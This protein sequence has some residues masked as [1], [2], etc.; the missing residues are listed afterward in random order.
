MPTERTC[1]PCAEVCADNGCVGAEPHQCV[2]CDYAYSG[3]DC[4]SMCPHSTYLSRIGAPTCAPCSIMCD[5]TVSG[6]VCTGPSPTDCIRCANVSRSGV[7]VVACNAT[8]EYVDVTGR[9]M[10]CHPQCSGGC[11]G[12]SASECTRCTRWTMP[13][14]TCVNTC[15]SAAYFADT[16]AMQCQH[17]DATCAVDSG[18]PLGVGPQHC[19]RCQ[20]FEYGD[21]CVAD[22]PVGSF[23]R[24]RISSGNG[25]STAPPGMADFECTP[26]H[27]LCDVSGGCSGP[28]ASDC[29]NCTMFQLVR[30][31]P[32]STSFRYSCV[33]TCPSFTY[34]RGRQCLECDANCLTGC[35]GGGATNCTPSPSISLSAASLGCRTA[36]YFVGDGGTQCSEECPVTHFPD[37]N[38]ICQA[39]HVSCGANGCTGAS[40]ADCNACAAPME[41]LDGDVGTCLPCHVECVGGCR[42][43]RATDCVACAHA[44]RDEECV[45]NCTM[46]NTSRYAYVDAG[47][48]V[49]CLR[50]SALCDV[51]LGCT[52]GTASDCTACAAFETIPARTCVSGCPDGTYATGLQCLACHSSCARSCVGPLASQCVECQGVRLRNGTCAHVCP[53]PE[54]VGGDGRCNCPSDRAYVNGSECVPCHPQCTSGCTG[55]TAAAC[56]GGVV[57]C[58]SGL[59]DTAGV[60]ID[61]CPPPADTTDG[62]CACPAARAFPVADGSCVACDLE[63][64]RGCSGQAPWE[65][66][67]FPASCAHAYVDYP[68]FGAQYRRCVGTCPANMYLRDDAAA[69]CVCADGFHVTRTTP[70]SLHGI[71]VA[72]D[73]VCATCDGPGVSGCTACKGLQDGVS[74]ACVENCPAL[75]VANHTTD[76]CLPCDGQCA[77]GCIA[78]SDPRACVTNTSSRRRC[79]HF[80]DEDIGC[81]AHCPQTR[82]FVYE[83]G[84]GER[85]CASECPVNKPF[86]NDTRGVTQSTLTLEQEP[87][88][89]AAESAT[90]SN[91][92]GPLYEQLCVASCAALRNT[93]LNTVNS[94]HSTMCSP[95]N[96]V[97]ADSALI[98][99]APE[100]ET[101]WTGMV[102]IAVI[103]V[104]LVVVVIAAVVWGR[105]NA[106][107]GQQ[108]MVTP[109]PPG[110]AL[111]PMAPLPD[112]GGVHFSPSYVSAYWQHRGP[113]PPLPADLS[114]LDGSTANGRVMTNPH[115]QARTTL[116]HVQYADGTGSS[117]AVQDTRV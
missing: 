49:A 61:T 75:T 78:P 32:A 113:S 45:P 74:G 54:V 101:N 60:C 116:S 26:C 30:W 82:F 63:C 104:V 109:P 35:R 87:A 46:F 89:E 70:T 88:S 19:A 56:N 102:V 23:V 14:G 114:A 94:N 51:R 47:G 31:H 18:C 83:D 68:A 5:G 96:L 85:N 38:G 66:A 84:S 29:N 1:M 98:R 39:C 103:V 16:T 28:L 77:A 25:S 93:T 44:R 55:P 97:S 99:P 4:V 3:V 105:R 110:I 50:C 64:N 73:G 80:R 100:E 53:A 91:I 106:R 79:R 13:D 58:R 2:T 10:A 76:M 95:D 20:Q 65:C 12:P 7:C 6:T 22:C 59:I 34:R 111:A 112:T 107:T 108:T 48:S 72:C 117:A 62:I 36:A 17:C 37:D 92:S 86:F 81:V 43:P 15:P 57:G 41:Y 52:G 115:Y 9:C 69:A 42:G 40:H 33:S 90:A 67:G 24:D 11:I 21:V 71:C 27:A 8:Q